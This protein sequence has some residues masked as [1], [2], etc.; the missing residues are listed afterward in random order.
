MAATLFQKIRFHGVDIPR[1]LSEARKSRYLVFMF[2]YDAVMSFV[3]LNPGSS[4]MFAV[5]QMC[6]TVVN[7]TISGSGGIGESKVDIAWSRCGADG[8]W[9]VPA[10]L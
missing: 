7:S 3:D 6:P 5:T 9:G 8:F 10:S 4:S 1:I 2:L